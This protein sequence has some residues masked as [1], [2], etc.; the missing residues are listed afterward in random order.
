MSGIPGG[1]D[2]NKVATNEQRRGGAIIVSPPTEV[3]RKV[4]QPGHKLKGEEPGQ[5]GRQCKEGR[6]IR[7]ASTQKAV[8]VTQPASRRRQG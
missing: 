8:E 4:L 7:A 6:K 1:P 3:R 2:A 5:R